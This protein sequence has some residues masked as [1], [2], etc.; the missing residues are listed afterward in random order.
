MT[1]SRAVKS[2]TVTLTRNNNCDKCRAWRVDSN[3]RLA[4]RCTFGYELAR[5]DAGSYKPANGECIKCKGAAQYKLLREFV[6]GIRP[7]LT[8]FVS[9]KLDEIRAAKAGKGRR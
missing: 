2:A 4:A 5:D 1:K 7:G 3:A 9:Q 6:Q 8:K